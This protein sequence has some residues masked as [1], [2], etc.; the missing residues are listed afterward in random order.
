MGLPALV[1]GFST[2]GVLIPGVKVALDAANGSLVTFFTTLLA[3]P[4][5]WI[6]IAIAGA[7]V[8]IIAALKNANDELHA[9]EIAAEKAAQKADES[10]QK[11]DE[12]KTAFDQLKASLEDH[13]A[14]VDALEDLKH[15]T[16]E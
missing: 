7:I 9:T 4:E 3:Q 11:F 1:S 5:F 10:R 14:A 13:R 15:G 6:F 2:L 16:E 12:M 8:G